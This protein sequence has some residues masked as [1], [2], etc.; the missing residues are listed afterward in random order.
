MI[1]HICHWETKRLNI[2]VIFPSHR[3]FFNIN[4]F[5]RETIDVS[6]ELSVII[7]TRYKRYSVK[8]YISL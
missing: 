6:K 1:L 3:T 2:T 7:E 5:I 8:N 4:R